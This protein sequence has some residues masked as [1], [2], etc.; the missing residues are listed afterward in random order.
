MFKHS[1][2]LSPVQYKISNISFKSFFLISLLSKSI[3]LKKFCTE[4]NPS[5]DEFHDIDGK[6]LA[7]FVEMSSLGLGVI[8]NKVDRPLSEMYSGSYTNFRE[9]D[10]LIAKIT[11]C[12]E[13]G[14]C[15]LA[16]NLTNQIG[17]GSTEFHVIRAANKEQAKYI[18]EFVNREYI[19]KVAASNMT[20]ASGHRRVPQYF[21]EQMPIPDAPQDIIRKI[22]NECE[23][24]DKEVEVARKQI[25]KAKEQIEQVVSDVKG[26]TNS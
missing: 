10:V 21:Y 6:T 13:N 12:M 2:I 17:F 3:P 24:V 20:G 22:V 9:N 23:A 11:P 14:K 7:S 25:T 19:R 26:E 1:E 8:D 15:A 4:I 16:E 18:L 5:K